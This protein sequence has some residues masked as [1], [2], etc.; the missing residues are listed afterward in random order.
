MHMDNHC[1]QHISKE[2]YIVTVCEV[3]AARV[4]YKG[5]ECACMCVIVCVWLIYLQFFGYV[6]SMQPSWATRFTRWDGVH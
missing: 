1:R 2:V 3:V 6:Q 4:C 5:H